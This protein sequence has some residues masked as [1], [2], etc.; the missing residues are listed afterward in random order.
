MS[1]IGDRNIAAGPIESRNIHRKGVISQNGTDPPTLGSQSSRNAHSRRHKDISSDQSSYSNHAQDLPQT[2]TDHG[3]TDYYASG[4]SPPHESIPYPSV[5][6][7]HLMRNGIRRKASEILGPNFTKKYVSTP[8]PSTLELRL[9][10]EQLQMRAQN[11]LGPNYR[12]QYNLASRPP[13]QNAGLQGQGGNM[14]LNQ[15]RRPNS[16][17]SSSSRTKTDSSSQNSIN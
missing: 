1:T 2:A 10:E 9:Q 13:I 5:D 12:Q 14:Q 3:H 4:S 15:D 6:E 11:I 8:P 16:S 7:L 17:T